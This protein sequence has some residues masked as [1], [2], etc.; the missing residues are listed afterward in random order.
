M[1]ITNHGPITFGN[2]Y[3]DA[4]LNVKRLEFIAELAL[5]TLQINKKIKILKKLQETHFYRKNGK[6]ILRTN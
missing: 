1:L 5:K 4:F 2:Y 3:D 6:K